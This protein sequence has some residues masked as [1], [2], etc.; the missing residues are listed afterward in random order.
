M[1]VVIPE[2]KALVNLETNDRIEFGSEAAMEEYLEQVRMPMVLDKGTF[3][4]R[5]ENSEEMI[6][7]LKRLIQEV[8]NG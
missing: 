2:E 5:G 4:V 6:Q 3:E 1:W 8:N 7:L